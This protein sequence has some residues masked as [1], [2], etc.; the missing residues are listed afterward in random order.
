MQHHSQQACCGRLLHHLAAVL[1]HFLAVVGRLGRV[2]ALV[3]EATLGDLAGDFLGGGPRPER[4]AEAV[5]R[6][7]S[8]EVI[9]SFPPRRDRT[10]RG[11]HHKSRRSLFQRRTRHSAQDGAARNPIQPERNQRRGQ[12]RPNSDRNDR[13]RPIN[14]AQQGLTA[15]ASPWSVATARGQLGRS[16]TRPPLTLPVCARR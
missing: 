15:S 5:R 2:L 7:T 12:R 10:R 8:L 3:R 4:G 11:G 1:Q 6:R 16:V 14:C 13:R 9:T